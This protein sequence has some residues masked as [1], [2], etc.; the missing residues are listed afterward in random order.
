MELKALLR[1][2][3]EREHKYQRACEVGSDE[4]NESLRRLG[5]L[6]D[7]LADVE[8]FES[9]S[10]RKDV[11]M[12]EE[13]NDRLVKNIIEGVKVG[14]GIVLPLVG[15]VAITAFEKSE[16]FTS[17]LKGIVSCFLPRKL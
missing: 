14:S 5:T 17:S 6:E 11:Q 3:I 1:E 7:K 4:Y 13:K 2:Q 16:T 10:A 8:K 15:L 12:K 9:E